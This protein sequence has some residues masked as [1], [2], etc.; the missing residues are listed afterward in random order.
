MYQC[1]VLKT[2]LSYQIGLSPTLYPWTLQTGRSESTPF[3]I[4]IKRLEID[5]IYQRGADKK[6]WVGYRLNLSPASRPP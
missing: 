3:E 4:A 2:Y 5:L 6:P 1:G